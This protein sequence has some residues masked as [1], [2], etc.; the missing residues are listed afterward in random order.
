[1]ASE[2]CTS[3]TK[4]IYFWSQGWYLRPNHLVLLAKI[5]GKSIMITTELDIKYP[6]TM[7][8]GDSIVHPT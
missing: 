7:V 1:M 3:V 5:G 4:Y 8:F 6:N 2:I